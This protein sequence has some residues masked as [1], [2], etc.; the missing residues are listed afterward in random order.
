MFALKHLPMALFALVLIASH[1]WSYRHG[2]EHQKGLQAQSDNAELIQSTKIMADAFA[3][4]NTLLQE[5]NDGSPDN[6][7]IVPPGLALTFDGMQS[8]N[9]KGNAYIT[10]DNK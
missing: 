4:T 3:H 6:Q 2:L 9:P 10:S 7:D 5:L 8:R 1:Y